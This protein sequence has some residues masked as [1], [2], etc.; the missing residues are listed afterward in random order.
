[1]RL[2]LWSIAATFLIVSGVANGSAQ[3]SAQ[4]M[5]PTSNTQSARP[6]LLAARFFPFHIGDRRT[7]ELKGEQETG[8]GPNAHM[9]PLRGLYSETVVSI[10]WLNSKTELIELDRTG[11]SDAYAVC[12]PDS[13]EPST[14]QFWYALASHAVL[15]LC[16]RHDVEDL[17]AELKQSPHSSPAPEEADYVLPF[18]VGNTWGADPDVPKR[19]DSMYEWVV[20]GL[21]AV[22]V[23]AGR[24]GNCYQMT[25]RTLPDHEEQWICEGL[26][27]VADEYTHNGTPEHYRIELKSV[28][29]APARVSHRPPTAPS[30][31]PSPSPSSRLTRR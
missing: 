29:P 11:L 8:S 15:A 19:N 30:A 23:P 13:D 5:R 9:E 16:S 12:A 25:F 4:P 22:S 31:P 27:L 1:M 6:Q 14:V 18:R 10:R 26:G 20:E 7:Y 17:E 28:T 3:Q 21:T 2:A 24:F